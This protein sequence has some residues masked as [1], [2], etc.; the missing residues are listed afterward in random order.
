MNIRLISP[1]NQIIH[2]T[3]I[4]FEDEQGGYIETTGNNILE[5]TVYSAPFLNA[6]IQVTNLAS[7]GSRF[8]F[9]IIENPS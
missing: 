2:I 4:R 3:Y 5:Q 9:K 1:D 7:H 6:K 8:N